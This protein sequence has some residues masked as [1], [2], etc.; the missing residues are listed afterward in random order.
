M[1]HPLQLQSHG[2]GQKQILTGFDQVA[3]GLTLALSRGVGLRFLHEITSQ[4]IGV[5]PDHG[6]SRLAGSK[7]TGTGGRWLLSR[8]NPLMLGGGWGLQGRTSMG[9]PTSWKLTR[10]R[11][12]SKKP[13]GAHRGLTLP[14]PS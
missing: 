4:Q 14:I 9:S 13:R 7:S 5:E 12:A 1:Q 10:L 6:R 2:L 11:L 8:P 3:R